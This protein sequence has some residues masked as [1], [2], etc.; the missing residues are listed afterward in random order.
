MFAWVQEETGQSCYLVEQVIVLRMQL[1][2]A[3]I[4]LAAEEPARTAQV[5]RRDYCQGEK[6]FVHKL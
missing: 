4:E 6:R 3:G 1:C 5:N 2:S